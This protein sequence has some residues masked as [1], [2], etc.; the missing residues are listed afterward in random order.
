MKIL[1]VDNYDSFTYNLVHYLEGAGAQL[2]VWRNDQIDFERLNLFDGFVIS[3]GP[4]LPKESG[5]LTH[6]IDTVVNQ[7]PMLG[8]CLGFQAIVEHYGGV[9]MNQARVKHGVSE[10]CTLEN[11][12]TLFQGISKSIQ[13]GLYHS[14]CA[15]PENFPENLRITARSQHD[16]IMAFEHNTDPVFGIQFHPESIMTENG[17][18][19]I[20]NFLKV[21]E[22]F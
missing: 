11:T 8:I 10:K 2:T 19:M 14:W 5:D 20:T 1:L 21:V 13:I 17:H 4:G 15:D 6:F 9:L 3:P 7:K 12:T 18:I 22:D 16:V